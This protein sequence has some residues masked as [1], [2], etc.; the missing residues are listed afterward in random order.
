MPSA[1]ISVLAVVLAA[2]AS[3]LFGGLWYGAF[4]KPWM[5]AAGMHP[6]DTSAPAGGAVLAP[7]IIAFAALVVMAWVLAAMIERSGMANVTI[8]NGVM[9]GAITWAGF[10]ITTLAVNHAFQN[11]KRALT[12]IDGGHWLGVLL[13]QGAIIGLIGG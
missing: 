5:E 9:T 10:V 4:S 12:L 2:I 11:Q 6:E 8:W 1:E 3:F 7:Y 13:I